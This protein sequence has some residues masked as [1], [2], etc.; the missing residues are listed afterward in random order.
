MQR[1]NAP[2]VP[3]NSVPNIA[4]NFAAEQIL[5]GA[6][7]HYRCA[8]ARK[9]RKSSPPLFLL[10]Q[11]DTVEFALLGD[12]LFFLLF[13]GDTVKFALWGMAPSSSSKRMLLRYDSDPHFCLVPKHSLHRIICFSANKN[14]TTDV[15]VFLWP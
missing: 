11:G 8:K 10:F 2:N 12:G 9:C 6:S 14:T 3:I 1:W 4:T 13:R 7:V 15:V 5:R